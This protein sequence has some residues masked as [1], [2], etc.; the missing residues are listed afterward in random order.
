[1]KDNYDFKEDD[2]QTRSNSCLSIS[3]GNNHQA[4]SR[5][6]VNGTKYHSLL[7]MVFP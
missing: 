2:Y 6:T 3:I 4:H 5:R 7:H 1:M